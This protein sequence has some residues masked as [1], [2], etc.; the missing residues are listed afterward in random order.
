MKYL[1]LIVGLLCFTPTKSQA[2]FLD[3]DTC[4]TCKDSRQHFA[5]GSAIDLGLQVLPNKWQVSNKPWK[6]VALVAL[7]GAVYEAGQADV[8][9]SQGLLGQRRV[10]IWS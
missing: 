8:A 4:W 7:V 2:Q 1:L 9:R 10:W 6:R 5:A 3:P